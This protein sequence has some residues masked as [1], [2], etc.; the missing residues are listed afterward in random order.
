MKFCKKYAAMM[1]AIA[2]ISGTEVVH[3]TL[4]NYTYYDDVVISKDQLIEGT[5]LDSN[6]KSTKDIQTSN[7]KIDSGLR[8]DHVFYGNTEIKDS[9]F[10]NNSITKGEGALGATYFFS[11]SVDENQGPQGNKTISISN[12]VFDG[13]QAISTS[14]SAKAAQSAYGGAATFKGGNAILTDVIFTNNKAIGKTDG[15]SAKGGAVRVDATSQ[16]GYTN[17][18]NVTFKITKDTAYT[19]NT[20][21]GNTAKFDEGG[22]YSGTAGGFLYMSRG[23]TVNFDVANKAE[24]KIGKDGEIDANTDSI[25]SA[26]LGTNAAMGDNVINKIGTGSLTVNGQLSDYHGAL[27]V[28]QGTMNINQDLTSDSAITVSAGALLNLKNLTINSQESGNLTV[29]GTDGQTKTVT[30]PKKRGQL[31]VSSN[32]TVNADTITVN[33]NSQLSTSINSNLNVGQIRVSDNA[34]RVRI[35]GNFTGEITD[36]NG[37]RKTKEQVKTILTANNAFDSYILELSDPEIDYFTDLILGSNGGLTLQSKDFT[38]SDTGNT[39]TTVMGS[40]DNQGNYDAKDHAISNVKLLSTEKINLNGAD[41]QETLS[42]KANTN[43]SNIETSTW[44]KVLGTGINATGNTGLITGDTLHQALDG[45]TGGKTYVGSDTISISDANE[46]SVK[47]NGTVKKDDAGLVTGGQV[48]K[49]ISDTAKGLVSNDLANISETGKTAIRDLVKADI[50]NKMDKNGANLTTADIASWSKQ[51]GIGAVVDGNTGLVTGGTVS[52]AISTKANKDASNIEIKAWQSA[53]GNGTNAAGN[54]GLITGDTLSKALAGFTGGKTYV[55]SDTISISDTN[56][57]SVKANGK[58]ETNNGGLVTGGQVQ[59]AIKKATENIASDATVAAKADKTYVD[60]ELAKKADS[61]TVNAALDKKVNKTD[62]DS[63]KASVD[64]NTQDIAKKAD[65]SYVN[66]ELAKKANADD[67]YTKA[68]TDK[69]IGDAITGVSDAVANKA[70]K[71][72]VDDGVAKKADKDTVTKL[73]NRV[74]G[75]DTDIAGLKDASGIDAA[76]YAEKLG[77]GEVAEG[78]VNLV[79]GGTVYKALNEMKENTGVGLVNVKEGAVKVAADSEATKVDF[80]GKKGNRVLTG[81]DTD[82]ADMSSVANVGYVNSQAEALAAGVNAMGSKLTNDIKNAGAVSAALAG[83]HP[84]DYDPENKLD[85]AVATGHYRGKTAGALGF[86]YQPSENV[87]ISAGATI[88]SDDN[89]YNA[90]VSFKIGQGSSSTTTSRAAMAAEIKSLKA[91][92]EAQDE[93]IKE[94][95]EQVALLMKKMEMSEKVEKSIAK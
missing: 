60:N 62:F 40:W 28:K 4:Y 91:D 52:T 21:S 85:V 8:W 58:V 71:S 86:F 35:R 16:G 89:A 11:K 39:V 7:V 24:L 27:N 43:A 2:L 12:T 17:N 15:A 25:A 78:N 37:N 84:L 82:A 48:Q 83:L 30:V 20:V 53:L 56:E 49:A 29:V 38:Q 72:Y 41:L 75:H 19:G 3:A 51:L 92:K 10:S 95:K 61:D 26:I 74:N 94:L 1:A 77:T 5:A 76:K 34:W 67:V 23:S 55:G 22:Y 46:I 68:E 50:S 14:N 47:V 57:I 45:I 64:K 79:N 63:I 73:E 33:K 66:D 88:G 44:Q 80:A 69:K 70:D 90:G 93:E 59:E 18:A 81:V 42:S 36:V 54:G 6:G 9:N 65:L 32:G 13:N 87:M 31:I